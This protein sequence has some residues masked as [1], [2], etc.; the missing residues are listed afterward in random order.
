M[1][2]DTTIAAITLAIRQIIQAAINGTPDLSADVV[3]LHPDQLDRSRAGVVNVY[4]YLAAI[5]P[6]L[7]G[8][9][10]PGPRGERPDSTALS[11]TLRYL[12]S[13]HGDERLLVP[14]RLMAVALAALTRSPIVDAETL[15]GIVGAEFPG[16]EPPPVAAIKPAAVQVVN[17]TAEDLQQ[18]WAPLRAAHALSLVCEART[19]L[20]LSEPGA[21]PAQ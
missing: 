10:E 17:V 4:L 1:N 11:L 16:A 15:A 6:A 20:I 5:D 3:S 19:A 14:Q 2:Q 21:G 7:R 13:F 9:P 12:L 8:A 18:I